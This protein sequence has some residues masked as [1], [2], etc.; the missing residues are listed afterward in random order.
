MKAISMPIEDLLKGTSNGLTEFPIFRISAHPLSLT[1]AYI[2]T[3]L[4]HQ[5][6]LNPAFP[7]LKYHTVSST[8]V[9]LPLSM[10]MSGRVMA[11]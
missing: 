7:I 1:K 5:N 4:R 6:R 11:E 9:N 8:C 10:E 3:N 2:S